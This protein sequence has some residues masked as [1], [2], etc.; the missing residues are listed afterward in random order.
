MPKAGHG[1]RGAYERM[2]EGL[3]HA[4]ESAVELAHHQSDPSFIAIGNGIG[5]MTQKIIKHA[6]ARATVRMIE[7]AAR[8]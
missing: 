1:E 4:Q 5:E 2:V 7:R 6:A 3:R 8:R